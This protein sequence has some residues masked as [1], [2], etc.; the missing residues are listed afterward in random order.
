MATCS[1]SYSEGSPSQS[2]TRVHVSNR[3]HQPAL[4]FKFPKRSFGVKKVEQRSFKPQWFAKWPF[5]HY[6]EAKDAVFCHT[7]I[8]ACKLKRVTAKQ[9]EPVFVST[10]IQ[11]FFAC[12]C[13]QYTCCIYVYMKKVLQLVLVMPATNAT[14]ERSFS[15]LWRVETY[16][17]TKMSQKRL[18]HLLILNVHKER[19]DTLDLKDTLNSFVKGSQH[20]AG[21]FSLF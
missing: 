10:C 12:T 8:E 7:C 13:M 15:A 21:L 11:Y 17:R 19:T 2:E 16:L 4:G 1:T 20:R 14:S 18:N 5:L 6:D 9:P 3:P